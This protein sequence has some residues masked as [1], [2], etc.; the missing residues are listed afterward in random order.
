MKKNMEKKFLEKSIFKGV[1][2]DFQKSRISES[3][4]IFLSKI[5]FR[6]KNGRR[7]FQ[8]TLKKRLNAF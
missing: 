2:L 6:P 1:L 5:D 7:C 3:N 8:I 4:K